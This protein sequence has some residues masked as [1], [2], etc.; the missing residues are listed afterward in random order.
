MNKN[1]LNSLREQIQ[2]DILSYL[3]AID[4]EGYNIPEN[5]RDQLCQIVV[6]NFKGL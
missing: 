3:E 5:D 1:Q 4:P 2:E 6:N